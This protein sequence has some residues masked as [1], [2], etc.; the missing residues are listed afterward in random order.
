MRTVI[1]LDA[2]NGAAIATLN[3]KEIHVLGRDLIERPLPVP[4]TQTLFTSNMS[5]SRTFVAIVTAPKSRVSSTPTNERSA[6]RK[7]EF[8]T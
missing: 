6:G 7:I 2:E 1:K 3:E 5:A 8:R 4:A